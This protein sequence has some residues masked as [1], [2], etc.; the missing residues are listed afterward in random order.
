MRVIHKPHLNFA[1][2]VK[3]KINVIDVKHIKQQIENTLQ[4][5]IKFIKKKIKEKYQHIIVNILVNIKKKYTQ[6]AMYILIMMSI[7]EKCSI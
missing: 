3:F 7:E 1:P 2:H 6:G 5:I 4:N